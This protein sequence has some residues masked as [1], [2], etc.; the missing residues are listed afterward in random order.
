M[1]IHF[2]L[3]GEMNKPLLVFLHGGGVSRWMWRE[4]VNYFKDYRCLVP[5]LPGHGENRDHKFSIQ[6]TAKKMLDLIEEHKHDQQVI[7]IGFSLGAQVLISML[8]M[9]RYLMD[10]A[11]IIS[12][13]TKPATFPKLIAKIATWSLPLAK[14]KTFSRMQAKYMHISG[15]YFNKYYQETIG[16]T[17]E[18]FFNVMVEN[19]TFSLPDEF[20]TVRSKMLI[21]IGEKENSIIKKSMKNILEKNNHCTGVTIPNVGHGIPFYNATYFNHLIENWIENGEIP[22]DVITFREK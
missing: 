10:R 8:S 22:E 20:E 5:D 18:A 2:K 7:G 21:L 15:E 9:N 3:Y 1:T 11:V 17:K 4:Q 13:S 14:I 16:M 6:D 12:A 19:M